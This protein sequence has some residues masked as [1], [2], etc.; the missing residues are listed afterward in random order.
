MAEMQTASTFLDAGTAIFQTWIDGVE[1]GTGSLIGHLTMGWPELE[2]QIVHG[3]RQSMPWYDQNDYRP[4]YSEAERT[5]EMPQ[6]WAIDDAD[7]LTA[8]LPR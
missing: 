4:Y 6:D 3:G 7:T 1:N 2:T 5:W 8:A